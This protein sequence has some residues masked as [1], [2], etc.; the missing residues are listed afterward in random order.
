M[1]EDEATVDSPAAR[2]HPIGGGVTGR[3][4]RFDADRRADGEL[5]LGGRQP[6]PGGKAEEG[7]IGGFRRSLGEEAEFAVTKANLADFDQRGGAAGAGQG[8]EHVPVG[9][10]EVRL[11]PVLH[12]G[13]AEGAAAKEAVE[14]V[15]RTGG[16][17]LKARGD[18]FGLASGKPG[19]AGPIAGS[20][21]EIGVG[22]FGV[23][24][25]EHLG[26]H[27]VFAGAEGGEPRRP[28]AK[29]GIMAG[30]GQA[31]SGLNAELQRGG[32][33]VGAVIAPGDALRPFGADAVGQVRGCGAQAVFGLG[34][35]V[36]SDERLDA[37][38]KGHVEGG[39]FG[40]SGERRSAERPGERQGREGC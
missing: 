10:D 16:G 32:I 25:I 28:G 12:R 37:R 31:L 3:Q 23:D 29:R 30:A 33:V 21:G 35:A 4:R 7:R 36:G 9:S 13:K 24:K 15:G 26:G 20:G 6:Q 34:V 39:E 2:R 19:A 27:I 40:T 1:G 8:L 14:A 11:R 22:V 17:D 38:G 5:I 18:V